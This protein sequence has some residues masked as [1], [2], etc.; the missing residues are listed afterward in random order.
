MWLPGMT[1]RGK[2][3]T[4]DLAA[5]SPTRNLLTYPGWL[6][7]ISLIFYIEIINEMINLISIAMINCVKSTELTFYFI[8]ISMKQFTM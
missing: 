1:G 4:Q 2:I 3:W 8:I 7:A 5:Q 6:C